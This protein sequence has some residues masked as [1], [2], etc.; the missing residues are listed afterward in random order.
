MTYVYISQLDAF[1]L[2]HISQEDSSPRRET[3]GPALPALGHATSGAA[4]TAISKLLLYPLDLVL[5]RLQVQKQFQTDNKDADYKGIWD[6][7]EKIYNNEGIRAFYSGVLPETLKGVADSFLFFLAYT[8]LRQKRLNVRGS[9]RNL[10]AL[11][12]IGVGV[13]AGA[14]SKLW[15]TPI[16]NIVTRKQTAA[17]VA[18]REPTSSVTPR[19]SMKD[20]ARQI[21]H[22][23]GT[24]GFWSGYSA[25]LV[26]T[27]NP[28]ITFLLHKMLLRLLVPRYRRADPGARMTFLLAAISKVLAS[29]VTYP[30]SLAKTRAQVSYQKPSQP[31]RPIPETEKRRDLLDA[32]AI[33]TRQRTVFGTIIRIAKTEG[34]WAL[35]Q[36]LGAEMLKGFFSHGITM[37]M[38]D[39]IHTVIINL[40]YLILKSMKK[41]PSP[42]E[43][44]EMASEQV[45]KTYEHGKEQAGEMYTRGVETTEDASEKV[46]DTFTNGRRQ[47]EG[48]LE[49]GRSTADNATK[50]VQD[51]L[52]NPGV[53]DI[54][55]GDQGSGD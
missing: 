16:Q 9:P 15:T 7:V 32:A 46:Q 31:T 25:S 37:L 38:K 18:A 20:I 4:G 44:A 21:R 35:Y 11:D 43:L 19:L 1:T 51:M 17:M 27:L 14:F 24:Q 8:Y 50:Q 40:Y 28:S 3:V 30:F 10:G 52:V 22:E 26:L 29:T 48:L 6:A 54:E 41:Y 39:Q 34:L 23:K 53:K 55:D 49:R 13:L 42:G 12:E 45:R 33:R 47:A 5:T 36:G 2:Y